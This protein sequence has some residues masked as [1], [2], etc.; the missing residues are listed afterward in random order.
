MAAT[1][2][3]PSRSGTARLRKRQPRPPSPVKNIILILAI[4]TVFVTGLI[5]TTHG[6]DF[7]RSLYSPVAIIVVIFLAIEYIALKGR[8][9]SRI[10]R[11]ELDHARTK[12]RQDLEFLRGVEKEI[13]EIEEMI[14]SAAQ[15]TPCGGPEAPSP[16]SSK[17]S[18][19]Q[20]RLA[21]LRRSL[22]ERL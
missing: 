12:R 10:Y 7:L 17:L 11:I 18:E 21:A 6:K 1:S 5:L 22:S 8:D 2:S 19:I 15:E 9:R 13:S 4:V 16:L 20:S 14:H 3:T